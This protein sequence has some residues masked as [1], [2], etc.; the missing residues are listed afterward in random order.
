MFEN[1]TPVVKY[2]RQVKQSKSDIVK[3]FT[4]PI[5]E[6]ISAIKLKE[7]IVCVLLTQPIISR[8][9]QITFQFDF[10]KYKIQ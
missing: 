5:V 10:S 2:V 6:D 4:Y 3:S 9:G 7:D 1:Q 8:R